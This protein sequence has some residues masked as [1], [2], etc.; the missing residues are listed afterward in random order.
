MSDVNYGRIFRDGIW[1][2]NVSLGQILAL[3]PLMAVTTSATNGLGMGIATT[4]VLILTNAM[5]SSV[6]GIISPQVRIPVMIVLIAAVVTVVDMGINAWMHSLYKVLGLFIAL[7]V[8]NCAIF[9]R[10][11]AFA[12][13]NPILPSM[14][15]ALAMGIGFSLVLIAVGG[16]REILGS[17]TLFAHASLLLGAHF[18]WLEMVIIPKFQGILLAILPPGAFLTLG[19]LIA[20]KRAIDNYVSRK[21]AQTPPSP[22]VVLQT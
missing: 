8:T 21:K 9:G 10:A 12:I 4:A 2:N 5:I 3:C 14:A 18:A 1:D 7:I 11:E 20:A 13:K 17:G 6:R 16:V 22:L 15:D 19:F